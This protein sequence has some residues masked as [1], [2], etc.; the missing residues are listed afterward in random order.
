MNLANN[1]VQENPALSI[2][3]IP[4]MGSS[5]AGSKLLEVR[6]EALSEETG[7]KGADGGGGA[8]TVLF[9]DLV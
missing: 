7:G 9:I 2:C 1:A 6:A 3:R 4:Y 8:I 5:K